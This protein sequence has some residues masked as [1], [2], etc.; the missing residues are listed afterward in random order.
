MTRRSFNQSVAA[1]AV[2]DAAE[3]ALVQAWLS[4]CPGVGVSMRCAA[5]AGAS[6]SS[7]LPPVLQGASVLPFVQAAPRSG[8]AGACD[9]TSDAPVLLSPA[10]A[11]GAVYGTAG[12][13]AFLSCQVYSA[14]SGDS[15]GFATTPLSVTP[16]LWPVWEDAILVAPS[17]LMRSAR[18]SITLNATAKLHA[19]ATD[20]AASCG[21]P[22][23]ASGPGCIGRL[24]NSTL[25]VAVT[26]AAVVSVA[27]GI[28]GPVPLPRN[29]GGGSL[30]LTLTASSLILLRSLRYAFSNGTNA[31]LGGAPCPVL[32]VSPD[33]LWA[34][35]Q[36]PTPA[37]LCGSDE[38]ECGYC[39]LRVRA[40]PS[41][42][43]VGAFNRGALACPSARGP[44]AL[45]R[46]SLP[47]S[48]L[49]LTPC[50]RPWGATLPLAARR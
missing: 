26:P 36:T 14:D 17:G 39:T 27:D 15:L 45:P 23:L 5:F 49:A 46:A 6:S 19:V 16:T 44:L 40:P 41:S 30:T 25:S 4:R 8:D 33:G 2:T 20:A 43:G 7:L 18:L 31:T 29:D 12:G 42:P 35:L 50:L 21:D 48:L 22:L 47:S 13:A 10:A 34:L 11:V 9:P 1:V 32:A 37:Q 24:C 3:P 28:W 38:V